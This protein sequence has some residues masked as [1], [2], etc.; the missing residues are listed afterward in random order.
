M[1]DIYRSICFRLAHPLYPSEID[2]IY[3]N[4]IAYKHKKIRVQLLERL[5]ND[6]VDLKVFKSFVYIML[7]IALSAGLRLIDF[8]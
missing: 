8:E 3:K 6:I 7:N 5:S 2:I 4:V 1:S